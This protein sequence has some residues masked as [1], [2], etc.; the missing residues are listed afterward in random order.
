[1]KA[2]MDVHTSAYFITD[3]ADMV[4]IRCAERCGE[5]ITRKLP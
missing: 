3:A 5:L 1:M 2:L 4:D